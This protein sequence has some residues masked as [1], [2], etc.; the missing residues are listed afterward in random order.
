ML[1]LVTYQH[2]GGQQVLDLALQRVHQ[3]AL[4]VLQQVEPVHGELELRH[5]FWTVSALSYLKSLHQG[6]FRMC[7]RLGLVLVKR[8][9]D[10]SKH[11]PQR[12]AGSSQKSVFWRARRWMTPPLSQTSANLEVH[13]PG[14]DV[15]MMRSVRKIIAM[16]L[17]CAVWASGVS[18][19]SHGKIVAVPNGNPV[20]DGAGA[21][22]NPFRRRHPLPIAARLAQHF[23]RAAPRPRAPACRS[24][25]CFPTCAIT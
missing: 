9:E 19:G 22:L 3:A 25:P 18:A 6:P 21:L 20:P 15:I 11:S 23:R 5:T 13:E 17:V 2:T 10:P 1:H 4:L 16:L 12:F 14:A 7:L 8:R 24:L